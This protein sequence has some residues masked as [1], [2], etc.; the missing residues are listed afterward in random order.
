MTTLYKIHVASRSKGQL[1]SHITNAFFCI[2]QEEYWAYDP[3]GGNGVQT[4]SV[5]V[6]EFINVYNLRRYFSDSVQ[7]HQFDLLFKSNMAAV[8]SY[9]HSNCHNSFSI[10]DK[11][12][13][14][15]SILIF[16]RN[17]LNELILRSDYYFT[18]KIQ[19]GLQKHMRY[20]AYNGHT[21]ASTRARTHTQGLSLYHM[22]AMRGD[23]HILRYT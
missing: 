5:D 13:R 18:K 11:D 10:C 2:S 6:Y 7:C 8:T 20:I 22:F 9:N 12:I 19:D 3:T 21:D 4:C 15:V 14:L 1:T 17:I 23:K 16:L